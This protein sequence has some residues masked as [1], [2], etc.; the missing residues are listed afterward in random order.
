MNIQRKQKQFLK[1]CVSFVAFCSI[2]FGTFLNFEPSVVGAATANDSVV[3][4]Q[5]VTSDI[6]ISAPADVTMSGPIYGLTGGTGNGTAVWEVK[7][8]D[9]SGYTV[10]LAAQA[11]THVLTNGTEY[12]LDYTPAEAVPDF[13]WDTT[14]TGGSAFGFTVEAETPADTATNFKD[15]GSACGGAG[16]SN[17]VDKCWAGFA[18]TLT[19]PVQVIN[20]SSVS[21]DGQNMTVKFKTQLVSGTTLPEGNYV[22]T[23]TATATTK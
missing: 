6:T 22:A 2:A 19:T 20:R 16:V 14:P 18:N 23:I 10:T 13:D 8:S 21:L 7:T 15:N 17:A 9:T 1:Q 5:A 3:V 12:F 4:T 11:D